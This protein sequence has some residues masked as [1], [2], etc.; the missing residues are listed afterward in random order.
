M[1]TDSMTAVRPEQQ[2]A[3]NGLYRKIADAEFQEWEQKLFSAINEGK[4]LG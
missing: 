3:R 1:M 2:L 4:Y